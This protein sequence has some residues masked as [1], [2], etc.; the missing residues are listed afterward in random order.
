MSASSHKET[1]QSILV[2]DSDPDIGIALKDLLA[3]QGYEVAL[4]DTGSGAITAEWVGGD[5][6]RRPGPSPRSCS[7]QTSQWGLP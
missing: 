2:V 4:V 7:H 6:F 5:S 3:S 1:Q